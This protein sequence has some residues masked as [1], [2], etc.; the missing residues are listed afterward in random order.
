MK[1]KGTPFHT[2]DRTEQDLIRILLLDVLTAFDALGFELV[3]CI[4]MADFV[5]HEGTQREFLRERK[6]TG[7]LTPS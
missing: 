3:T 7:A 6:G 1:L 5:R 4:E 2:N